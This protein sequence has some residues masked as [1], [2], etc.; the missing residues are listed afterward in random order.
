MVIGSPV[1]RSPPAGGSKLVIDLAD[2]AP[3]P[4]QW[5][6]PR[7]N[8]NTPLYPANSDGLH[9]VGIGDPCNK[10]AGVGFPDQNCDCYASSL[11]LSYYAQRACS[12]DVSNPYS[13]LV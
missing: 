8:T 1:L 5:T 4:V 11:A 6:C 2:G 12:F 9:G 3:Q 10:G 7:L 13:W